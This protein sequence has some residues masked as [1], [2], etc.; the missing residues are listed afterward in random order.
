MGVQNDRRTMVDAHLYLRENSIRQSFEGLL[1]LWR[2]LSAACE[3]GLDSHGLGPAHYR[4]MFF[5]GSHGGLLPSELCRRLGITK[6]SLG[7]ALG[8]L[9][10][11]KLVEQKQDEGDRRKRPVFLTDEGR[12]LE[13]ELFAAIRTVLTRAYRQVDGAAVDGFRRVLHVAEYGGPFSE[14]G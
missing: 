1:A 13:A 8:E 10:A 11:K 6:Q 9:K 5:L 2:S 12:Q 7:R 4:I 3:G 14:G